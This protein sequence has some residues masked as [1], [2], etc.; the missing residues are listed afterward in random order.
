MSLPPVLLYQYRTRDESC[1]ACVASTAEAF[2]V[3]STVLSSWTCIHQEVNLLGLQINYLSN[4]TVFIWSPECMQRFCDSV[5]QP[6]HQEPCSILALNWAM[7]DFV[8]LCAAQYEV[9]SHMISAACA[10]VPCTLTCDV[11]VSAFCIEARASS[12]E[13]SVLLITAT[14]AYPTALT[15]AAEEEKCKEQQTQTSMAKIR[16][17]D[18]LSFHIV[19]DMRWNS[20]QAIWEHC[21]YQA[22]HMR[23]YYGN[24]S[25][26]ASAVRT[27][28]CWSFNWASLLILPI[29]WH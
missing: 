11:R 6:F 19:W 21:S 29:P 26:Q 8:S 13:T 5:L 12:W 10:K 17:N 24:A 25:L 18:S 3:G 14:E 23:S 20:V 9:N 16:D 2:V 22:S 27:Q 15:A 1:T 4:T 28:A 7:T